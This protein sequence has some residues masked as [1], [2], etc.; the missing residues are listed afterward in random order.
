MADRWVA[1]TTRETPQPTVLVRSPY[2]RRHAVGLMLGRTLAE[3]GLQVLVQS[4][5]G[6]FDSDGVFD[7]FDERDDGLATLRWIREQ[8]WHSER[9]ALVG[10]SYL[11]LA[12]WAAAPGAG[13]DIAALAIQVGSSSAHHATY[14]GGSPALETAG[15]WLAV[16]DGQESRV[17]PLGIARLVA[18]LPALFMRLPLGA[19]DVNATGAEVGWF[20]SALASPA[21]RRSLVGRPRPCAGRGAGR[22][23]GPARRRLVRHLPARDDGGPRGAPG[24]RAGDPADHRALGAH[25]AGP[26]RERHARG[27]G[28]AARIPARRPQARA[29]G[30][31]PGAHHRR[32]A[33]RRL[34][35][36]RALAAA[37]HRRAAAV[38]RRRRSAAGGRAG[39]RARRRRALPLRPGAS[40]A[41]VRRAAPARAAADRR[42]PPARAARRRAHVHHRAAG[43]GRR[44]DRRRPRRAA[45]AR[46]RAAL[47]PLRA[48]LRRRPARGVAQRLRCADARLPG[49]PRA[50]LRRIL[51]RRVRPVADGP[52]LRRRKPDPPAD[53]LRRAPALRAQPGHRRG[54]RSPPPS[55]AP[56][57]SSCCTAASTR[58][59]WC[60][61]SLSA[62]DP[63]RPSAD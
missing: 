25:V 60:C 58:R 14:P 28:L 52:S 36:A 10:P 31:D 1:R 12:M 43:G 39:R 21:P 49:A 17:P 19:F 16:I 11:G 30:R 27:A 48:R 24:R 7:A 5:R 33:R 2:G 3:R 34:A 18:R 45:R 22:R 15:S 29:A 40:D 47:R 57:T 20:R 13:D 32:A 46:E 63:S 61:R 53:L 44:G 23:A 50:G 8:P 56:S 42:Q 26:H 62:S 54:S 37:G 9:I 35:V 55:C 59:T 4:V 38:G 6:T 41:R 51:A